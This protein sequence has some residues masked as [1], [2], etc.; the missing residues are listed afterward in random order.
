MQYVRHT[1]FQVH[2][3]AAVRVLDD[4]HRLLD[5]VHDPDLREL[6]VVAEAAHMVAVNL[7]FYECRSRSTCCC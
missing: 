4:V 3:S 6:Q 7:G 2:D 5:L 1:L